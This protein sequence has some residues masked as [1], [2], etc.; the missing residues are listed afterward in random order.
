MLFPGRDSLSRCHKEGAAQSRIRCLL[1]ARFEGHEL[2]SKAVLDLY[3]RT[4]TVVGLLPDQEMDGGWRGQL[5]LVPELP[6][7]IH[8]RQLAWVAAGCLAIDDFFRSLLLHASAPVRYRHKPLALLFFRSVGRTTPSAFARDWTVAHNVMGSLHTSETAVRET[9]FHEVFHL[10]DQAHNGWVRRV[11]SDL[12]QS[13]LTRC[14]K[15]AAE[16]PDTACLLRY[17]PHSTVVRGGTFYAFQPGNGVE[18]YGAE[19]AVRYFREQSARLSP[20]P[21]TTIH[22]FKCGPSPNAE[23]WRLLVEE[24]FGGVD[25]VPPCS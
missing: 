22:P 18:E 1:R 13:I 19:L 16:Q 6:V 11:L 23:A 17:A 5:R 3:D 15:P 24:F 10:N 4:G 14:A 2:E 8:R 9:L 21:G 20:R 12:H 7:G 25:L